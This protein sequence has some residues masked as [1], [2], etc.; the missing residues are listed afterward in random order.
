[1]IAGESCRVFE[2]DI[3]LAETVPAEVRPRAVRECIARTV[4]IPAGP[5][6]ASQAMPPG[7][8]IGLFVLAGL[9]IRRVDVNGRFG[10]ELLGAGDLLRPWEGEEDPSTLS[11]RTGWQAVESARVAVLDERFAR[12]LARYPQAIGCLVGR[13]VAR[14][15]NLTVN[16]AIVHQAR[17]DVRVHMILWHLAARWGRVRSDG[18]SLPLRLTHAVLADLAAA[19][20]P[21]VSSALSELA[22]Q[23]VVLPLEEDGWLLAGGPP[24][25]L[26]ELV[27]VP[28]SL[29]G[30][31]SGSQPKAGAERT[32]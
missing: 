20:R 18:V 7:E 17:V 31:T 26:L 24:G 9:L 3:E 29:T 23:G 16:M 25:E 15:R 13:A 5:W 22:R 2:Q 12:L 27:D 30:V 21:T 32:V 4:T 8:G 14:A 11:V 19:R 10:A 6:R 28:T 1:M